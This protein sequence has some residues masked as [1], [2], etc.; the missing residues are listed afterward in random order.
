MKKIMRIA[1]NNRSYI[2]VCR[3]DLHRG[4]LTLEASNEHK[5]FEKHC[6]FFC[7]NFKHPIYTDKN[8]TSKKVS[9]KALIR[10]RR[11]ARELAEK[12][13]SH[14]KKGGQNPPKNQEALKIWHKKSSKRMWTIS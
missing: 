14:E 7:P 10:M 12:R 1:S 13:I 2:G 6:S 3:N 8:Y 4:H 5:C 11:L 9:H